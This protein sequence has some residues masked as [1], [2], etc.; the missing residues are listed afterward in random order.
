MRFN[1]SARG[2]WDNARGYVMHELN[3]SALRNRA[4]SRIPSALM[5]PRRLYVEFSKHFMVGHVTFS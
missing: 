1:L 4:L 2:G 3:A 5:K